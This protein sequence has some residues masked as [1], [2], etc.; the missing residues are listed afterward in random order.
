MAY[1][2]CTGK[3]WKKIVLFFQHFFVK[4]LTY[5]CCLSIQHIQRRYGHIWWNMRYL[6]DTHR[7]HNIASNK[8]FRWFFQ[9]VLLLIIIIWVCFY[10][11]NIFDVNNAFHL[12]HVTMLS[13]L[14]RTQWCCC[15]QNVLL[16]WKSY[17]SNITINVH[18]YVQFVT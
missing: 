11:K 18:W 9:I 2:K 12:I 6:K 15:T 3:R 14:V 7:P 1:Q 8:I 13:N 5:L 4:H 17:W 10:H 16:S